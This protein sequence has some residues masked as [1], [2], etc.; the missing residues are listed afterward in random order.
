[1]LLERIGL[2]GGITRSNAGELRFLSQHLMQ[3]HKQNFTAVVPSL[4]V[5]PSHLEDGHS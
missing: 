2:G 1:M 3:C 4:P 5:C